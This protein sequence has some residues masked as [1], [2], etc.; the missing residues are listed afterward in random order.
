MKERNLLY[1]I[2]AVVSSILLVLAI[3]IRFFPFFGYND[4]QY[5]AIVLPDYYYYIFPVALLW[6]AWIFDEELFVLIGSGLFIVFFGLH[7]EN[8]RML[9][10]VPYIISRFRPLVKT[11]YMLG[12]LLMVG[13]IVTGFF[14]PIKKRLDALTK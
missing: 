3:V 13:T 6:L 8:I 5:A 9:V 7:V 11:I 14:D 4:Y 12:L 10:D 2:T 1:F